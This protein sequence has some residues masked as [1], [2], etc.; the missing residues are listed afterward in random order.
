MGSGYESV[1]NYPSTWLHF[2]DIENIHKMRESYTKLL[3]L[4]NDPQ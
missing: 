1:E 2:C 3:A 4:C